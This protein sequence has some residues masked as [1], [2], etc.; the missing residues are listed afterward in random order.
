M[1]G[2]KAAEVIGIPDEKWGEAVKAV[3]I[4]KKGSTV[5]KDEIIQFCK[6]RLAKYE[7]PKTVEFVEAFPIGTTG[8][9]SRKDL[10]EKYGR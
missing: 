10:K 1:E 6:K 9:V 2:I 7:V 5:S 3:V 4:R 8:K